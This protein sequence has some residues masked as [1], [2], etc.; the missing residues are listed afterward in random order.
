MLPQTKMPNYAHFSQENMDE[1]EIILPDGKIDMLHGKA[2]PNTEFD[3]VIS[4]IRGNEQKRTHFKNGDSDRFGERI[5]LELPDN[6][7]KV[8]IENAKGIKNVDVFFE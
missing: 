8:K 2:D 5:G 7:Y 3:I 4:D 1:Q 6:T